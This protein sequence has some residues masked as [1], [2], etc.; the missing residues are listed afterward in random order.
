[1]AIV[2][3]ALQAQLPDARLMWHSEGADGACVIATLADE[4]HYLGVSLSEPGLTED[5]LVDSLLT[6]LK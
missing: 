2:M 1:M 4:E 3:N 6:A 5:V